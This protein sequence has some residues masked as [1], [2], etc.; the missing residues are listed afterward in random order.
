[1]MS[2]ITAAALLTGLTTVLSAQELLQNP[3][4]EQGTGSYWINPA[5]QGRVDS[6]TSTD[7]RQSLCLEPR[8]QKSVTVFQTVAMNPGAKF[9]LS[10]DAKAQNGGKVELKFLL[11]AAKPISFWTPPQPIIIT[12]GIDW[13]RQT[14][15]FGPIPE[16][17][18][19]QTVAKIGIY[20]QISG[21]GPVWIDHLTLTSTGGQGPV[22][23]AAPAAAKPKPAA[24]PAAKPAVKPAAPKEEAVNPDAPRFELPGNIRIYEQPIQVRL[25]PPRDVPGAALRLEIADDRGNVLQKVESAEAI[26]TELKTPGY[27][28]LT[29]TWKESNGNAVSAMTSAVIT[30]PLPADYYST[31]EPAFGVWGGLNPE[32][33]RLGGAKWTRELFF[34][35]FQKPDFQAVAPTAEKLS[36]RSPVKV[37]RC[38]NVLNPFRRMEAVPAAD[39]PSLEEKMHKELVSR[40]GLVDVW[41]TQNEPM[42][43]E[44]FHGTMNDVADIITRTSA[45][46]RKDNPGVPL[47]GIC[48][49][50]MNRNQYVQITGYYRNYPMTRLIDGV[51]LHP[52]IPNAASPDA[53]GYVEILTRLGN[54]LRAI[55][56]KTVPLYISEIGYSTKPG[57][58]V[59]EHQ[60]AAYLAQ[61]TLL[62]RRIPGLQACV[63]H[64]GLWN[65][66]TSPRELDYGIL[67]G[68]PKKS[69]QR[70]PKPAFAAWATVSRQTYNA[71]YRGDLDFGRGIRV[72]LFVRQ[73]KPLLIAYS[74]SGRPR[75][76]KVPLSTPVVTVTATCG[77]T[78]A[79]PVR[80][81]IAEVTVDDGP[82]YL[83]G[84]T[85]DDLVRLS[86]LKVTFTPEILHAKPGETVE[87]TMSGAPLS[88]PEAQLKIEAPAAWQSSLVK[89]NDPATRRFRLTVPAA[90]KPEEK[91]FYVHLT[92]QGE[93]RYIWQHSLTIDPP[94]SLQEL[95]LTADANGKPV[96]TCLPAGR[97]VSGKLRIRENETV[98]AEQPFQSGRPCR[99]PL[100]P[101][102]YGQPHQYTAEIELPGNYSWQTPLPTLNRFLLAKLAAPVAPEQWPAA[103]TFNL[104][105][106]VYSRHRVAG[107]FDRPEGKL[108]LGWNSTH[109][110]MKVVCHDRNMI[111]APRVD[112]MWNGDS[113]QI[114]FS[115]AQDKMIKP[116]N[117]GI[118]E[119]TYTEF[120]LM[121]DKD[122]VCQSLVWSSSNRNEAELGKPLPGLRASWQRTGEITTY[123]L[124]IPWQALNVK[125][126]AAGLPVKLSMV[127]NDCDQIVDKRYQR[128]W[129]E[130]YNGIADG[131]EPS[132]YGDGE[133]AP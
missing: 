11:Q 49:N 75:Q 41:E 104:G 93:S 117:D 48:I 51:M 31:P 26:K 71:E 73:G 46:V 45:A 79:L 61:V 1:M 84:G 110:L 119:T 68:H 125:D 54:E 116:N 123:Q 55:T 107:E 92:E 10:L 67:R 37:I 66:A 78:T 8:D 97:A 65:D 5:A 9:E 50:P 90:A 25:L 13:S 76:L 27:Y 118:Q 22:K 111:V 30:T 101:M 113:L 29:G 103:S 17:F 98:L 130:W 99:I 108:Y 64:I 127:V 114:G 12:P 38:L 109:L 121:P 88:K 91:T 43:G 120:G 62:N 18:H 80:N 82:V 122:G 132:L 53:S 23:S 15:S 47:A 32:M 20:L 4:F 86:G 96:L 42:V 74:I 2:K 133:L 131:K 58:E 33:L 95:K 129:L 102:K 94:V 70:E 106:G 57:G 7:G 126:P 89:G 87:V 24:K 81:G 52:Y 44:N 124:E 115:I 16:Q 100:P 112:N 6:D 105:D 3:S 128:H 77:E 28:R 40:R 85:A 59:T 36:A 39:W 35:S 14:F 63:W 21:S 19:G 60:Q 83:A 56:G 69:L 34:T 72:M